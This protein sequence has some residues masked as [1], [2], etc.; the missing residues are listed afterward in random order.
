V[1][2]TVRLVLAIALAGLAS[3][4]AALA[5]PPGLRPGVRLDVTVAAVLPGC[6]SLVATEGIP[7]SLDAAFCSGLVDALLYLGELLP[8]DHCYAVPLEIPRDRVVQAIVHE[9]EQVYPSVERQ[10]FR[11]LALEVLHHRWPC[12]SQ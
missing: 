9:I 10:H 8:S 1:R 6:R 2:P 4:R 12:H 3:A 5:E 7:R 11:G